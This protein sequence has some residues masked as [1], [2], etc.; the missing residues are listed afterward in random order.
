[1]AGQATLSDGFRLRPNVSENLGLIAASRHMRRPG[2][3]ARLAAMSRFAPDLGQVGSRMRTRFKV[4][5]LIFV[6]ALAR[7]R[8]DVLR[9]AFSFARRRAGRSGVLRFAILFGGYPRHRPHQ[10]DTKQNYPSGKTVD[11]SWIC[12]PSPHVN[13]PET[14]TAH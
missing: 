10:E 7:L 11:C 9:L 5:E 6:A 14:M 1:M 4:L 13:R 3:M 8:T 12:H 2:A